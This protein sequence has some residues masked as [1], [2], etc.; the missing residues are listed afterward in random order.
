MEVWV[1]IAAIIVIVALAIDRTRAYRPV[2]AAVL[3]R[4]RDR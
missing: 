2:V 1:G 3:R 4:L